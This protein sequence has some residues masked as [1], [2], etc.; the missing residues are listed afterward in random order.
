M[1]EDYYAILGVDRHASQQ[2]IHRAYRR[3]ALIHHPDL[4]KS[5]G[6]GERFKRINNAYQVLS[7]PNKRAVYNQFWD[8]SPYARA[9][10]GESGRQQTQEPRTEPPGAGRASAGQGQDGGDPRQS[11]SGSSGRRWSLLTLLGVLVVLTPLGA[12][13]VLNSAPA[14]TPTPTFIPSAASTPTPNPALRPTPTPFALLPYWTPTPTPTLQP[15]ATPTLECPDSERVIPNN[16]L[17]PCVQSVPTPWAWSPEEAASPLHQPET[18]LPRVQAQYRIR[19]TGSVC[20]EE[21][22]VPL[23]GEWP[24]SIEAAYRIEIIRL[25]QDFLYPTVK[26]QN[27]AAELI[28]EMDA[29]HPDS[30]IFDRAEWLDNWNAVGEYPVLIIRYPEPLN[31]TAT[32][33]LLAP[34]AP[35][36][37]ID[38]VNDCLSRVLSMMEAERQAREAE[39]QALEALYNATDGPNWNNNAF[40]LGDFPL[41]RWRGVRVD[42]A[43]K[44]VALELDGNGLSG[45]I[46]PELGALA[47]LQVLHLGA[48]RLTG[49]IPAEL[50]ALANLHSL[51]LHGNEL[52]GPIPPGLCNLQFLTLGGNELSGGCVR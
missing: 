19:A 32:A 15:D 24:N 31:F 20:S 6:A 1:L 25:S 4:D 3:L 40:W 17:S 50:G 18:H 10:Q 14:P 5:P 29:F 36:N 38:L 7:E 22:V 27:G 33:T 23:A 39:R 49:P 21:L 48:N 26:S 47:N 46:P 34:A 52:S 9:A 16:R 37:R 41:H 43:G 2:L 12:Y 28:V 13:F 8:S 51:H 11:P 35:P 42:G 45:R 44:V 30:P